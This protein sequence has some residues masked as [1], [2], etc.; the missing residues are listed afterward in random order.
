MR[1]SLSRLAVV[2]PLKVVRSTT[3]LP[4][5]ISKLQPNQDHGI[6]LFA[7]GLKAGRVLEEKQL[8]DVGVACVHGAEDQLVMRIPANAPLPQ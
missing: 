5:V 8:V 6:S 2:L 7:L 4:E 1:S 3:V